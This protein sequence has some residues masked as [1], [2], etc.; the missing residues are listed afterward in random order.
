MDHVAR[1]RFKHGWRLRALLAAAILLPA[2]LLPALLPPPADAFVYW[3][4]SNMQEDCHRARQQ[5][6]QRRRPELHHRLQ[7]SERRH[8]R[9]GVH[10]LGQ[11][12]GRHHRTGQ[13]RRTPR[14]TSRSSPAAG[15]PDYHR[16]RRLSRLLDQLGL[17]HQ[18]EHRPGE[19]RRHRGESERDQHARDGACRLR[20]PHLLD[21][22]P[23]ERQT[24]EIW[25]ARAARR[26]PAGGAAR[27]L[28]PRPHLGHVGRLLLLRGRAAASAVG[29]CPRDRSTGP[30]ST[31]SRTSARR[32]SYDDY[33]Y[34]ITGYNGVP[35]EMNYIG[36]IRTDGFQR[37]PTLHRG[38]QVSGRRPSTAAASPR[39]PRTWPSAC[40][41]T[42]RCLAESR[43]R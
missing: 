14:S 7:R 37:I 18:S 23:A 16:R 41:N 38:R 17:A 4:R 33:I 29:S 21:V 12:A 24:G 10:L 27:G 6:R 1:D 15:I 40:R 34:W 39:R 3:T 26:E 19:G 32:S 22:L 20:Q 42:G 11:H 13:D 8:S 36:E 9:R 28:R 35:G 5:R 43:R 30:G 25:M 2:L 31:I